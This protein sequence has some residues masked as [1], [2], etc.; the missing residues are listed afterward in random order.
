MREAR[1]MKKK[2]GVLLVDEG[3]GIGVYLIK[4]KSMIPINV[5]TQN[6]IEPLVAV[7]SRHFTGEIPLGMSKE[8]T[9]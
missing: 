5:V 7:T 4:G 8:V 1:L 2:Y 6:G 3:G 9:L